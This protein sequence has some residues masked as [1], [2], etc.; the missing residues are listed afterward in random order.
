MHIHKAFMYI[1]IHTFMHIYT[2]MHTHSHTC[3]DTHTHTHIYTY[4]HTSSHTN[5]HAVLFPHAFPLFLLLLTCDSNP[6]IGS[7]WCDV[8]VIA[9]A[10][11]CHSS[12]IFPYTLS[13]IFSSN[14]V[15]LKTNITMQ[16]ST[17]WGIWV[18]LWQ[19]ANCSTMV[20]SLS[21]TLEK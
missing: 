1:Y 19:Q 13:L 11:I 21:Y 9:S 3:I 16:W 5:S 18:A 8:H 14:T 20:L 6:T 2:L 12:D 7:A 10:V 17:S 4:S 15:C